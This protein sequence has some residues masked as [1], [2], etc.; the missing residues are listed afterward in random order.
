MSNFIE[1][2][3]K[4]KKRVFDITIV[5][6]IFTYILITI[7]FPNISILISKNV[8]VQ[9]IIV[10]S[11]IYFSIVIKCRKNKI[12][13]LYKKYLELMDKYILLKG[14]TI[15]I[16]IVIISNIINLI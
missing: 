10:L 14:V 12:K 1:Y 5:S 4:N 16:I 6:L 9:I 15:L 13:Q 11:T 8:L 7:L 2:I 3:K